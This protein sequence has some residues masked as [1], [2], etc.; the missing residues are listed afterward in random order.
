MTHV[1]VITSYLFGLVQ[2]PRKLKGLEYSGGCTQ[3]SSSSSIPTQISQRSQSG[4]GDVTAHV[5][6]ACIA[7]SICKS[8]ARC[9][10]GPSALNLVK[11]HVLKLESQASSSGFLRKATTQTNSIKSS[12]DSMTFL[13]ANTSCPFVCIH[14]LY[15]VRID[16]IFDE[17]QGRDA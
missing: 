7:W 12:R 6:S 3:D 8:L 10:C 9:P 1:A 17:F 4:P 16:L 13:Q 5:Y 11:V 14:S 2:L 15:S